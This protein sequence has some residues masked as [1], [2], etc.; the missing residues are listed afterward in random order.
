MSDFL[1][2]LH[3]EHTNIGKLLTVCERFIGDSLLASEAPERF[4]RL[5][6]EIFRND[7]AFG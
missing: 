6:F 3:Q 5:R 2:L 1:R 7:V 4:M